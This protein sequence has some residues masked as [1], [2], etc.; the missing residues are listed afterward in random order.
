MRATETERETERERERARENVREIIDVF[1]RNGRNESVKQAGVQDGDD[2]HT[3]NKVDRHLEENRTEN[4]TST[5][6]THLTQV[7]GYTLCIYMAN[8]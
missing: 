7:H 8:V 1:D 3:V 2:C 4:S 5:Q 6:N